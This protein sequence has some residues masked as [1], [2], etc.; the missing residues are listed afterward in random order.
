LVDFQ[1]G[2][3]KLVASIDRNTKAIALN[4]KN[5]LTIDSN[6]QNTEIEILKISEKHY[7]LEKLS[8]EYFEKVESWTSDVHCAITQLRKDSNEV[9]ISQFKSFSLRKL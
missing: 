7:T 9:I 8:K 1:N 5:L 2:W 6:V 4:S 3:E